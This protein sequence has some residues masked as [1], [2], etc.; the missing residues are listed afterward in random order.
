MQLYQINISIFNVSCIVVPNKPKNS[1]LVVYI[2]DTRP[3]FSYA[4]VIVTWLKIKTVMI[5]IN[6]TK[7]NTK[8][9]QGRFIKRLFSL[10]NRQ[11]VDTDEKLRFVLQNLIL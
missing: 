10:S 6:P 7:T 5:F 3:A 9:Y 8:L 1:S 2:K 4:S 11:I